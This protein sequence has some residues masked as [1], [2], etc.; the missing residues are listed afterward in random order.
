MSL[1]VLSAG[2]VTLGVGVGWLEEEFRAAGIEFQTR[3]ARTR[4]C[5]RALKA[6][7][8]ESEPEFH[9]RFFDFGPVKFEPKPV[10]KP[11]PPIVFGGESEA[12]LRR[13]ADLG[14]GWYGVGHSPASAAG[15]A[16][17]LRAL[18]AE[19]RPGA[20]FELT[21]SHGGASL[22]RGDVDR[23]AEAGIDRVVV[24]PWRRG[25]EAEAELGRLAEAV[26]R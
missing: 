3:A 22:G 19:R 26:L 1:D 20:P 6:L 17:K 5:V 23:Y 14:D 21:V 2:R 16:E 13:A 18:L 8:T 10:Q 24:L 15:Q 12:A 11:H 4:E 25:R 9:G 7:W